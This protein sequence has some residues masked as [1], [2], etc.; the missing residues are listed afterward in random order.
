MITFEIPGL[1]WPRPAELIEK[2]D[3]GK[4]LDTNELLALKSRSFYLPIQLLELA[5]GKDERSKKEIITGEYNI[6]RFLD[7]LE[8]ANPKV[9]PRAKKPEHIDAFCYDIRTFADKKQHEPLEKLIGDMKQYY[10][11][12]ILQFEKAVDKDERIF[13][14]HFTN[15]VLQDLQA[16]ETSETNA[17]IKDSIAACCEKMAIGMKRFLE[18]GIGTKED[19]NDYCKFVAGYVGVSLNKIV[20]LK[21]GVTLDD[22]AALMFGRSLQKINVIKNIYEDKATRDVIY[23]PGEAYKE[24]NDKILFNLESKEGKVFRKSILEELIGDS[25]KALET[26]LDYIRSVDNRLSGYKAFITIPYLTAVETLNAMQKACPDLIFAGKQEAIK[27]RDEAF[28]NLSNFTYKLLTSNN[29]EKINEFF[30]KYK[31]AQTS[32]KNYKFSFWPD[33]YEGW[34]KEI[35]KA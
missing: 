18:K 5:K 34:S 35:L 21:D 16:R 29:E 32:K 3:A 6:L 13:I 9:I 8:D 10:Y 12:N 17:A 2:A 24:I 11:R 1:K 30:D 26:S 20:S 28:I 25:R 31:E 27:L 7:T 14:S 22:D 33:R 23:I 15:N 19:L 4:T